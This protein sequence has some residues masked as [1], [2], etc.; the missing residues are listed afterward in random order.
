MQKSARALDLAVQAQA[1]EPTLGKLQ[2]KV[3]VESPKEHE[4]DSRGLAL[5]KAKCKF[6][7]YIIECISIL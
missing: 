1:P 6:Y 2:A 4:C 5:L 3:G 7:I